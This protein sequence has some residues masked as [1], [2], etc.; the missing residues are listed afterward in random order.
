[1][2]TE[3][4]QQSASQA[5]PAAKPKGGK[6]NGKKFGPKSKT[7]PP[8]SNTHIMKNP[9]PLKDDPIFREAVFAPEITIR[10]NNMR[11]VF[12]PS[13]VGLIPIVNDMW[14]EFRI[15]DNQIDRNITVEGIRYYAT[16]L[17]WCRIAQLKRSTQQE[18]TE[19]EEQL[20]NM[21]K[22]TEFNVPQPLAIYLKALGEIRTNT[23]GQT[24]IPDF[25]PLPIEEVNN[26]HGYYGPINAQNHNL[27]E[28]I[29]CLGVMAEAVR[30]AA[31]N[32][33][34]GRYASALDVPAAQVNANLLGFENLAVRRNEGRNFYISLGINDAVF[35]ESINGTGFNYDLMYA[36]SQWISKTKTFTI[37]KMKFENMSK[38]GAQMQTILQHPQLQDVNAVQR[39][40]LSDI[41]NTSL[42]R[43]P[44][45]NFGSAYFCLFQLHKQSPVIANINASLL[46]QAWCCRTYTGADAAHTIPPEYIENRNARR[47]LPIEYSSIRFSSIS[48][49]VSQLRRR[50]ITKMVISR[51]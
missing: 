30:H 50:T 27:Y 51:R 7:L 1:M 38:I 4:T 9:T 45:T 40:V 42:S 5:A 26:H 12:T 23:T 8:P 25:P 35:P 21:C 33:P 3:E 22:T 24:L 20:L 43:D 2:N 19:H 16:G 18:V 17:F 41:N 13:C 39:N 28:E 11:T 46:A 14:M 48:M 34:P 36:V 15:D 10:E 49:S 47:N 6:N 32:D 29:P 31:S 37:E 44:D